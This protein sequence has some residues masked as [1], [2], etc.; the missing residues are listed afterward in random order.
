MLKLFLKTLFKLIYR[1][2]VTGIENFHRAGSRVLIVA[3]HLSF[4]DAML[5][6]LYLPEKPM[7][8]INSQVANVWYF[9]PLINLVKVFPIDP[10]SAMATRSMIKELKKDEKCVIFPEGRITVTGS[11][12]KIYNG[13]GMI[14][15]KS[16]AMILPIRI[17]GAQYTLFS[18]LK[19]K[20]RR[21]WFQK[22]TLNI[23][24]PCT[25]DID[26]NIRG[27]KR[28]QF[29]AIKLYDIM[30]RMVFETSDYEKTLFES[31]IDQVKLHG[32]KKIIAEDINRKPMSNGSFLARSFILAEALEQPLHNDIYVGLMMPNMVATAVSF[33]AMQ[34]NNKIPAMIN[35]STGVHNVLS[36]CDTAQIKTVIS[37]R[38]FIE[39]AKLSSLIEAIE[40]HGIKML[41]L[42]DVAQSIGMIKKLKGLL[43][44]FFA[45]SFYHWNNVHHADDAAVVLFTSG[46]EG[47]PK[48]VVLS[49]K[50]I[51]ANRF[52]MSSR[53]DFGPDDLVFNALP[54]F[55]S[56][57]LTGGTLMTMLSGVRI[58]F[59]PSPLHYRIIPE[60]VY[61][62]NATLMFGTDTFLSGY[63]RFANPY[64]FYAV[65][66]VF[67]GAE[68]LKKETRKLWSEKYGVRILEGYGA[69]E[70][71]PVL[72]A[73]TPMHNKSGTVG[74]ILPGIDYRLE[75]VPGIEDGGKLLVK[76][77]NIMKGYL[78]ANKP[79]VIQAPKDGEYDTGDI[80]SFDEE[81][82]VSI[83]G[84]AKRFAKIAG[85]MVSLTAV[86]TFVNQLWP[87]H[88]HAVLSIP[89]IK[90]GEALLLVTNH[91]KANKED[92]RNYAKQ[93]GLADL[94]IPKKIMHLDKLPLLATGKTDYVL[95]QKQLL[96]K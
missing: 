3:N 32:R 8:A 78:L 37:S 40:E 91:K 22:I 30:S 79:G 72:S 63:A 18:K 69:T 74:R 50:N 49:H 41:Y 38:K 45:A 62:T 19:G 9:K 56:F 17:N 60:L 84:R 24:E 42:E 27:R 64:D 94:S 48:G 13:P 86:E 29:A 70:T 87:K 95:L 34:V 59:Y 89:D 15:D 80:V 77:P 35:F 53:V 2:E 43:K 75:D 5:I 65:R 47:T 12:M 52:Q 83:E 66:Y 88:Q 14:A 21:R 67:A 68:K 6:A 28:R 23:L 36:T 25:L 85:E 33:F 39:Q 55:H 20:V 1:V 90:K 81:G 31:L 54:M 10:S 7:F 4:L 96:E 57:G 76:G 46:S 73:N 11:L 82:Y 93:Q 26:E 61:D 51:Q 16:G 71:S 58:F 92:L 44:S